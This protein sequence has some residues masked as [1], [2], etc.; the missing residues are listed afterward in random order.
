MASTLSWISAPKSRLK[1]SRAAA[2]VSAAA[3]ILTFS[4]LRRAGSIIPAAVPR[5]ARPQRRTGGAC[6]S[7]TRNPPALP[8]LIGRRGPAVLDDVEQP[9][10]ARLTGGE[11]ARARGLDETP[12]DGDV[13]ALVL[14]RIAQDVHRVATGRGD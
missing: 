11:P 12:L 9:A 8:R 7:G 4:C 6:P 5:P 3:V 1:A 13:D 14:R 10:I 2:S